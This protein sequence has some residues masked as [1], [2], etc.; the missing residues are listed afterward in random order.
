MQETKSARQSIYKKYLSEVDEAHPFLVDDYRM[1]VNKE[2]KR[3]DRFYQPLIEREAA[4]LRE[5]RERGLVII[6]DLF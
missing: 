4:I 1:A 6:N 3:I 5:K 2:M